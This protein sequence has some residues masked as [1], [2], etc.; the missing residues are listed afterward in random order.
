MRSVP[1]PPESVNQI[2]PFGGPLQLCFAVQGRFV[3]IKNIPAK[4]VHFPLSDLRARD[5][6]PRSEM[7]TSAPGSATKH[8][9]PSGVCLCRPPVL[10]LFIRRQLCLG[11]LGPVSTRLGNKPA[12]R[13]GGIGAGR[14]PQSARSWRGHQVS[15]EQLGQ[16]LGKVCGRPVRFK[17]DSKPT[18]ALGNE[19]RTTAETTASRELS[20]T[21]PNDVTQP[22]TADAV[23]FP[24]LQRWRPNRSA[25]A[26]PHR[27]QRT[28]PGVWHRWTLHTVSTR[29]STVPTG[30]RHCSHLA[31]DTRHL[32][33][34]T[35]APH[36]ETTSDGSRCT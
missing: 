1:D 33:W 9:Q 7:V 17:P 12:R 16:T 11:V 26:E 22:R 27:S 23:S 18:G 34:N 8:G 24:I 15:A 13:S 21:F 36:D 2:K 14:G 10:P 31:M 3:E 6:A 4:H 32:R 19:S 25:R 29:S 28:P 35:Q 30:R 5:S 20:R